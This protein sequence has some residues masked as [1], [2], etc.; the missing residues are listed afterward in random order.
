MFWWKENWPHT[1]PAH[2][3]HRS[4]SSARRFLLVLYFEKK[5][6]N[7]N[8]DNNKKQK[9]NQKRNKKK[10]A[11]KAKYVSKCWR[12]HWTWLRTWRKRFK[13][14]CETDYD[15]SSEPHSSLRALFLAVL[16]Q[17]KNATK[18][19]SHTFIARSLASRV[20]WHRQN[21]SLFM[22]PVIF[23]TSTRIYEARK[24]GVKTFRR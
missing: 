24:Y 11:T 22:A 2:S 13:N 3:S 19:T 14:V 6:H 10:I 4:S 1:P 21:I 9:Q 18:F 17:I 12:E 20:H 15:Q 23:I 7:N 8:N 16:L 5:N